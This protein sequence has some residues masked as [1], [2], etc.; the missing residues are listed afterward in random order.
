MAGNE[1]TS[2]PVV[3][4]KAWL[5]TNTQRSSLVAEV[6]EICHDIGFFY[7]VGHGVPEDFVADYFATMS[8]F[9]D[10]PDID[11]RSID[12]LKS[13][14]FRGW[15]AVGAELT[16]NRPD[17]REQI[18]IAVEL[19]PDPHPGPGQPYQRLR[20]PNQ[21]PDD[22]V[23]ELRPLIDQFFD[24]MDGVATVIM[25]IL[26]TGLGLA[27]DH[28]SD[29]FGTESMSLA[30]L[31]RYP[32]TPGGEAGVGAHKDTGFLTI[33]LQGDEDGLQ[34]EH[35]NGKWVDVPP[36]SGTFVVNIGEMF[37]QMTGNYFV[38][39]P[40]RVFARKQ[41][42]TAGY[43]H[44]PALHTVLRPLPL[45]PEFAEAVA[46]SSRHTKAGFMARNEDLAL[47]IEGM[48]TI[49]DEQVFGMQLWNHYLRSYPDNVSHHYPDTSL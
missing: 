38:A 45:S 37:Q 14:H 48:D 4:L 30:K 3:D 39:T 26:S 46:K 47:G 42:H 10:L 29:V 34:A 18:D 8:R 12:K 27:R 32:P 13:P 23:P 9:F 44:S 28:L 49:R 15:E 20:G 24:H 11:K 16:N 2:L 7:I 43:F 40:H 25:E 17:Q 36:I 6:R 21:L 35:G 41:R 19:T 1:L 22:L 33:L 31:I 5:G